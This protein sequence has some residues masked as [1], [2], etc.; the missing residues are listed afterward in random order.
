MI[1]AWLQRRWLSRHRSLYKSG[2][3][4]AA[5]TILREESTPAGI[6]T[7]Y[8][9]TFDH[10]AFDDGAEEAVDRLVFLGAVKDDRSY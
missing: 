9:N 10:N 1:K 3:D 6:E 4:W 8:C 2:Y 5:G 7:R